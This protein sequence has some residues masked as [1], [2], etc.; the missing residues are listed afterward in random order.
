MLKLFTDIKF[1]NEENRSFVFPL[2]FDLFYAKSK[3]LSNYYSLT[4]DI[5]NTDI[6]I[7]P[8]EY[9]LMFKNHKSYLNQF[10]AKA[11]EIQKPVWVYSGGDFGMS[12]KDEEIY[13]FRLSGFKSKLNKR[14]I[15]LPSFVTDPYKKNIDGEFK[16]IEKEPTPSLGFVGHAKG[17]FLSI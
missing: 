5:N 13:N 4:D 1:L 6:I 14:T 8:L 10:L 7:L 12:L 17:G 2:V 15:I 3:I 16:P 11:K 9:A